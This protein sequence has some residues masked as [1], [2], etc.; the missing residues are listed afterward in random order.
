MAPK[1][2]PTTTSTSDKPLLSLDLHPAISQNTKSHTQRVG[3]PI[4]SNQLT[5]NLKISQITHKHPNL[6][7]HTQLLF[8]LLI[9]LGISF[10]LLALLQNPNL[11][12]LPGLS[13]PFPTKGFSP[14]LWYWKFG[15]ILPKT[16]HFLNSH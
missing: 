9:K 12:L 13:Y 11:L 10:D 1:S 8:F 16:F 2:N 15:E 4:W 5:Q 7:K 6:W 14:I 3:I